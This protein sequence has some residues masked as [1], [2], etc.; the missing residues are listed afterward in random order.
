MLKNA[1]C[2][3]LLASALLIT[4]C[5]SKPEPSAAETPAPAPALSD[6]AVEVPPTGASISARLSFECF[7]AGLMRTPEKPATCEPS[8]ILWQ[9][10]TILLGNDKP[11]P[12]DGRSPVFTLSYTEKTLSPKP[13]KSMAT[14]PFGVARKYEDFSITPDGAY[15]LASTG[16]DRVKKDSAEQDPYSTLLYWP[17]GKPDAVK[18]ANPSTRDG[19]ESSQFIRERLSLAMKNETYPEGMPY[20]KVEAMVAIPGNV[21]LFGIREWGEH[22]DAFN[23][24]T[25]IIAASYAITEGTLTV[26]DDFREVYSFETSVVPESV[27]ISSLAYDPHN[28]QLFVLTSYETGHDDE[29]IGGYLW[30]LPI[31][32]FEKGIAP[33][34]VKKADGSPLRFAHKAEGVTVVDKNTVM[35]IHDDDRVLGRQNV[36]NPETQFSRTLNQGFLDIVSLP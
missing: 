11:I 24:S 23:Y 16:F 12:G 10:G 14:K 3:V 1:P 9:A 32:D 34:L 26:S 22:Y 20:F 30:R 18:V 27:A 29:G 31:A 2:S 15:I 36:T 13:T 8:A 17:K 35:V 4:A 28:S 33:Q 21:L 25:R 5:K 19:I 7:E 6:Q